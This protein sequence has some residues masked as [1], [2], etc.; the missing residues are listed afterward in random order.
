MQLHQPH[1]QSSH[2]QRAQ[3]QHLQLSTV[4]TANLSGSLAGQHQKIHSVKWAR[5]GK[6]DSKL[7]SDFKISNTQVCLICTFDL[8]QTDDH[9]TG[10]ICYLYRYIYFVD[11]LF[12]CYIEII[13]CIQ[14]LRLEIQIHQT[15]ALCL[16]K[17]HSVVIIGL[18]IKSFSQNQLMQTHRFLCILSRFLHYNKFYFIQCC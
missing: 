13:H 9:R 8:E 1:H 18:I 7:Y 10:I 11:L 15:L 4:F 3:R 2:V 5:P 17:K 12:Y 14:T 16:T 6:V